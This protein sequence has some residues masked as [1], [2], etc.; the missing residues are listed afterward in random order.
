MPQMEDIRTVARLIF[1]CC[2][3]PLLASAGTIL[4]IQVSTT[5]DL[6]IQGVILSSKVGSSTSAPTDV[7]GKTQIVLTQEVQPGD[8]VPLVLVHAP[9]PNLIM[10]APFEGRAVI[11]KLFNVE[12]VL[13]TRGD[14]QALTDKRVVVSLAAA[15]NSGA[16][17]SQG[18]ASPTDVWTSLQ[19]VSKAT[20]IDPLKLDTAIR[21]M[22][23]KHTPD[24]AFSDLH[25]YVATLPASQAAAFG[26]RGVS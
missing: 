1:S 4:T 6:P 17:N 12:V 8:Q 15:V 13:A 16:K 10:F 9:S 24:K 14:L 23:A 25:G 22:A 5:K 26:H 7:A 20:G 19:S 21:G 11:P 18:S 2:V 3:F